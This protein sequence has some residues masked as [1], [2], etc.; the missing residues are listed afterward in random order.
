MF[1]EGK[2]VLQGGSKKKGGGGGELSL[3]K[4][5]YISRVE[6]SVQR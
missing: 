5:V 6:W 2:V 3:H 4:N 1:G